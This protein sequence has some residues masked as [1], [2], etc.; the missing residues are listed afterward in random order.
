MMKRIVAVL[1]MA[2]ALVCLVE[3]QRSELTPDSAP[4]YAAAS[5]Q[6]TL[7][8]IGQAK[9]EIYLIVPT[10]RN[11]T[12]YQAIR[13]RIINGVILRLLIANKQGYS[14]LEKELA[15]ARNVDARWLPESFGSSILVVDDSAMIVSPII[16][17]VSSGASSLAQ[18]VEITRP[19]LVAA[20]STGL[21]QIFAQARRIK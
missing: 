5:L 19:E 7:E 11:R 16:S 1:L 6:H 20:S 18:S 15:H 12:V 17:G 14:G 21:K 3:A 4:V 9:R 2:F 10:M 13:S 8:V